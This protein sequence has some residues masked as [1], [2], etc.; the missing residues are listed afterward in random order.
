MSGWIKR[1]TLRHLVYIFMLKF[2]SGDEITIMVSKKIV[3]LYGAELPEAGKKRE[4]QDGPLYGKD[5]ILPL[6]TEEENII[7]WTRKCRED[8]Q[9]WRFDM[10]DVAEL[11]SICLDEGEFLGSEWCEQGESGLWVACDAYRVVRLEWSYI[12]HKGISFEYYIKFAINKTGKLV[13]MVSCH[14]SSFR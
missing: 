4:I 11:I 14:P 2:D 10:E 3:S 6:L 1:G 7:A 12:A 5:Q 13:L 8:L 9:K